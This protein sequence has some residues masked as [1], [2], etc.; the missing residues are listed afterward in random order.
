VKVSRTLIPWPEDAPRRASINSF[1]IGGSNAHAIIEQ[2][3]PKGRA[4]HVS[5]YINVQNELALE[6]DE[7]PKPF[8]VVLSANDAVSLRSNIKALC[9]HLINPRVKVN[10]SDLA[11]TLSER[12]TLLFHRAFVTTRTTDLNEDDF[13]V[14]K[15][16][17]QATKIGFIFTGQGAQ[18]PRMGKDLVE[19]FPWTRSILE[20][21]DQ[22]LQAQPDPPEWSLVTELTE[23][24]TAT[25]MRQPE[26]SQPLVT[27]LQ[28]CIVEVLKSWN[29][30]PSCV[31]G[32]S[33]GECAAAYVAGWIDRAGA[34]KAAFYRG[35]AALNCRNETEGDVGMLAIGLGAE[36]ALPFLSKYDGSASIAC[37]NS[38]NSLTISGKNSALEALADEIKAAGY[39]ARPLQVDM[40][41]HSKFMDVPGEEYHKLLDSDDKFVPLDG[42]SSGVN[43]FSSVTGLKK[44]TPADSLYWKTNM[45]SPVRFDDA[46][47]E[48]ITKDMPSLLIEIG[49]SGALGGPVSQVLKSLPNGGDI[50]YCASWARGANAGKALFDVAGRLFV[51][52]API[53]ISVVNKY[54]DKVLTIIDLPNYS[55]NH[56]IK[57]WHESTASK[58]WRFRKYVAHDLLGSK[59]LGTPWH[60]PIWRNR[61]NI[62]N[63]PWILDHKMGGD[64][65]MPAAGFLTLALEALYQK[66]C[67]LNPNN[68][69]ASPNEL[70]YRFRNVRFS[71][72]LVLEK[73]KDTLLVMTLVKVPGN[74]DWHE[75]RISTSE[76]DIV[77]E[78]CFGLIRI[79]DPVDEVLQ[80]IAPLKSPQ[81]AGLWYKVERDI[82][83]EFG[84]AFQKLISIEATSGVRA[85]RTLVSLS[86]PDSPFSPQSYYPIHPAALDGCFQTPIPANMAGERINV[87]DAMIPAIVDDVIINKVPVGLKEGLSYATSVYS[88]RGRPD[89]D[90]S[91][92]ANTSVYDHETGALAM[93]ITGLN[94]VK[95]DVP[96]RPDPHTF[97]L[98]SWQPDVTLLT[99]DQMMYLPLEK[100]SRRLDRVIDLIAYKNPALN[101]L[102]ISLEKS[103][104][105]CLWF[106]EGNLSARGRYHKYDFASTDGKALVD[107]QTKYEAKDNTSFVFISTEKEGLGLSTNVRYD[108][109]IIK[110]SKKTQ[111]EWADL[112]QTLKPFF[113]EYTSTLL[114][115]L[116]DEG[117]TAAGQNPAKYVETTGDIDQTS[118]SESTGRS[119]PISRGS[120][121][122]GS[123]SSIDSLTR[124]HEEAENFF[125]RGGLGPVGQRLAKA[126]DS[127]S[128]IEIPASDSDSPIAYLFT[129]INAGGISKHSQRNLTI[130]YLSENA[131]VALGPSLQATLEASGWDIT[132]Q[133]YPFSKPQDGSV[134]L[135][136]D[137]LSTPLLRWSSENQW[138]AVKTLITS[139]SPVL[140]I[141]KGAQGVATNPDNA[142]V[143]GLFRVARHEDSSLNI[144]TLDVQSSTSRATEWAIGQVLRL[145]GQDRPAESQYMERDGILHIQRLIPDA[146]VNDFKRAEVEGYEP[147]VKSFRSNEAQVQLRAERLGTLQSL[148][149]CETNAGEIP[150]PEQNNIEVEVMAVGVNF[151]D[152]AITMG[153]VPDN[154]YNIG[155]ECSGV[156][157]RLGVGVTKF[158]IGD[159]VCMLKQGTYAN[160][161][162]VHVDRCHT[163]PA[164]MSYEEAATIPSV[165]LCSLYALYHLANLQEG[166]V[167]TVPLYEHFPHKPKC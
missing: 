29:I 53:D 121:Q 59:I 5:S 115:Q 86:P 32:H 14:A 90:K 143:H 162:H 165:Y 42:S 50:S 6:E 18:W 135:I 124:D 122:D 82:G 81:G 163:I 24:R 114:V 37:F 150:E 94:Y 136:L 89:Q 13:V 146:E 87:R 112:I 20:E 111:S 85:C 76:A 16:N 9:T 108:L 131:R 137:E 17:P 45:V 77:A 159:H 47:K 43:L 23:P 167:R 107:V 52:G 153:I 22:V 133:T 40:A 118:P 4:N 104:T 73:D 98:L 129:N 56:T 61:L 48:M 119:S 161:I 141:T 132:Q 31:V 156:V 78:H 51:T 116:E 91:W 35:R 113:S 70:C 2:A 38:P 155:F 158:K 128:V 84:P 95:L 44:E 109:V 25:H 140:W 88:G 80:D 27:A 97:D 148:T 106:G 145:L 101:V 34:L 3:N 127:S 64:A 58:D 123:S 30:T 105:S 117:L 10:L 144:T 110:T 8:T 63:V 164:S 71:R 72:A 54:D 166:Q 19:F 147:V 154:E 125:K 139:G 60:S 7:T 160:R 92:V 1:G 11:Y 93:R 79:Q 134:V 152:V 96:P 100:S 55:W 69:P 26:M 67:A 142:L 138:D 49:P 99:Q 151:K 65:I 21:L 46:L 74:K 66:H 102:E 12:R 15:K 62:A 39:F 36:A 83:M 41:Y 75:F 57:Y 103:D 157:T 120:E 126:V 33:S 28:L 149:W 130:A 68:A